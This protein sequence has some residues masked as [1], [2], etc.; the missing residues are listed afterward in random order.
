M[1]LLQHADVCSLSLRAARPVN[2]AIQDSKAVRLYVAVKAHTC[3]GTIFRRAEDHMKITVPLKDSVSVL[4]AALTFY[5]ACSCFLWWQVEYADLLLRLCT[6]IQSQKS[7][8]SKQA[9]TVAI[10]S[11]DRSVLRNYPSCEEAASRLDAR[12][13]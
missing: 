2:C 7:S 3:H 11:G 9:S 4:R 10:G 13:C 1:F 6:D 12:N 5:Q 8:G